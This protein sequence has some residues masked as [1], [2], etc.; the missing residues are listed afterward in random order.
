MRGRTRSDTHSVLLPLLSAGCVRLMSVKMF[1]LAGDFNGNLLHIDLKENC[2]ICVRICTALRF[3]L[4]ICCKSE[5]HAKNSRANLSGT[6][7]NNCSCKLHIS[8]FV[9]FFKLLILNDNE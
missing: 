6:Q 5:F 3:F 7:Q 1:M 4:Q 2:R 9:L 8:T